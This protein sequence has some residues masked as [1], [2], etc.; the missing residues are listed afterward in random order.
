MRMIS[1]MT[2][3]MGQI[4]GLR[5]EMKQ[6]EALLVIDD[7]LDKQFRLSSKLIRSLSEDELIKVMTTNGLV[8]TENIAAI[9]YLLKQEAVLHHDLGRELESYRLH[10]RALKLFLE[11]AALKESPQM[12]SL[13]EQIAEQLTLLSGYELP[14]SA[15]RLLV[16]WHESQ[17]NY[18][19][20]EDLLYEL[21]EDQACTSD[22]LAETYR[23]LLL[24]DDDELQAGRLTRSEVENSLAALS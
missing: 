7:L 19:Q 20:M 3:A 22:E 10:V 17:G 15:K 1:Q 8:E 4:M 5:K 12:L 2:E 13:Q 23:R 14:S 9:A 11:L 16:G 24:L 6:E 18:D 21:Y